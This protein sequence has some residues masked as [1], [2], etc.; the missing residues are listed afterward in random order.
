M[1]MKNFKARLALLMVTVV[2]GVMTALLIAG[3]VGAQ[4]K[5]PYSDR[6]PKVLPSVIERGEPKRPIVV[7]PERT[8][9]PEPPERNPLPFTG[10]DLTLFVATGMAA[11]ATG[12]VILRRTRSRS[13]Q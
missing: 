11:I 5:D 13:V 7:F 3:P 9:P 2:I 12:T 6:G 4:E 8:T 10:A 1:A